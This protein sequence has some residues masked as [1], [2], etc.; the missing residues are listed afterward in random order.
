MYIVIV[1]LIPPSLRKREKKMEH[2]TCPLLP[3]I[4]PVRKTVIPPHAQQRQ[5]GAS[6]VTFGQG[7]GGDV[8]H[9]SIIICTASLGCVGLA[10]EITL[11]VAELPST[12]VDNHTLAI[13]T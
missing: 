7:T 8:I 12:G 6:M 2:N 11:R 9:R 1:R 10:R 13:I 4:K 5:G 3:V